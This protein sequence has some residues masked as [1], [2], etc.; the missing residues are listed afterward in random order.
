MPIPQRK[1]E[2]KEKPLR[3]RRSGRRQLI[4][5]SPRDAD[6]RREHQIAHVA[7]V[8]Q[9]VSDGE[10]CAHRVADYVEA[11]AEVAAFAHGGDD[12]FKG[13]EEEVLGLF[14]APRG[15]E[16][17]AGRRAEAEPVDEVD[18]VV[19]GQRRQI[20]AEESCARAPAVKEE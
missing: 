1:A 4:D 8:A 16:G 14:G 5:R 13:V 6:G 2:P 17:R 7:R 3:Q 18:A 11:V 9:R 20:A 12:V 10:K 15:T 19:D